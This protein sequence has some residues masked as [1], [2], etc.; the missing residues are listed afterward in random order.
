MMVPQAIHLTPAQQA[1]VQRRVLD[2][3]D[4]PEARARVEE[5]FAAKMH[6]DAEFLAAQHGVNDLWAREATRYVEESDL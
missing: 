2:S 6:A 5:A 4:Y 1:E 3:P